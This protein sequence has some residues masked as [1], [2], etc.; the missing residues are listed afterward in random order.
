MSHGMK[1][2]GG[3]PSC[4]MQL[5]CAGG[6]AGADSPPTPLP[7]GMHGWL[8]TFA[9][10]CCAALPAGDREAYLSEVV[11]LLRPVLCDGEGN[12]TAD[13]VRLRFEAR[14]GGEGSVRNSARVVGDVREAVLSGVA[15]G[16]VER[17][18]ERGGGVTVAEG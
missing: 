17:V 5:V 6:V 2:A 3:V 13:Y 8:E 11:D 14:R 16:R 4:S 12:W 10:P 18:F 7:T 9:N 15:T 1:G